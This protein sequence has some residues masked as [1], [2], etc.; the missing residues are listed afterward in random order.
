MT[1]VF[2]RNQNS[3]RRAPW[4]TRGPPPTTPAVVPTAVAVPLP[5]VEVILPK[6]E[7]LSLETGLEKLVW[8]KRL[9]KS[10]RNCRWTF[11]VPSG[12]FLETAKLKL[13]KPGP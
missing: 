11:S 1:N 2:L 7:L 10:A 8:L 12:K 4:I 9:K 13:V 5:T 6:F 3:I